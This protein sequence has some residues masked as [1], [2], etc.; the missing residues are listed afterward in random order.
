MKKTIWIFFFLLLAL[1]LLIQSQTKPTLEEL[2]ALRSIRGKIPGFIVWST[3]RHGTWQIYRMRADGTEKARLTNDHEKNLQ[4]VW[5]K[6][7]EWIYYQRNEDIYRMHS[8]GT[9]P[10]LV[11][12]NGFSF[13]L[14]EDGSKL[15]Y[16]AREE[17]GDLIMIHDLGGKKTEEIIPARVSRFAGKQLRY[18]TIS[19]DGQWIAFAS[20]YPRPWTIHIVGQDGTGLYEL[21]FG[22]M[23][24]YRPD[25]S[26]IAWITSGSHKLYVGTPDGEKQRPFGTSIP[27]RPHC[28]FPRWSNDGRYIVFAASP[29]PDRSTSDYEIY[30]KP[31]EGG[32][33]VRLT[34]HPAS[35]TWPDI[36]IPGKKDLQ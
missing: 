20:A 9:H 6:D 13:D 35:D 28:Y 31:L 25:G 5:S 8:D 11:V 15:I 12:K 30:I 17:D 19:P 18:P 21:S 16:V 4:P 22:C 1:S 10:Q 27:G 36:Y 7:G 23:P 2:K 26:L 14:S 24:Q 32:K 34:F 29:H 3:A 33:A